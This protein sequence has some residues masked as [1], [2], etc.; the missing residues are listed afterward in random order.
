MVIG[1][2]ERPDIDD[3]MEVARVIRPTQVKTPY[4]HGKPVK[5]FDFKTSGEIIDLP[6]VKKW[7]SLSD[8]ENQEHELKC[9]YCQLFLN[10]YLRSK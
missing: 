5:P 1:I 2:Y 9:I 3:L 4:V 8:E 6:F 10:K 7:T